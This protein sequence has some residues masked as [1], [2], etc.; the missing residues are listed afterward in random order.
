MQL[1]E[2]PQAGDIIDN[3][4][5]M[6]PSRLQVVEG[7]VDIPDQPNMTF[8]Y[9][10]SGSVKL[11]STKG[12]ADVPE[13]GY[14][15]LAR[16]FRIEVYGQ[17]VL[18]TRYGYIGQYNVG[19]IEQRGRL[20]YIDGCSDTMLYYP[21]RMGDPVFNHLHFPRGIIQSQ[22]THPSVRLG[23]VARGAGHAFGPEVLGES[24]MWFKALTKGCVF[25]LEEQEMHS[26]R[27]DSS[28][29]SMDVIAYH[30][31]SD[32]GPTDQGHPM[33]NRTYIGA[34]VFARGNTSVGDENAPPVPE[35]PEEPEN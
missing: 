11:F 10:L 1:I 15:C 2:T 3:I 31:D 14:F 24:A 30:P 26:F 35:E 16:D 20:S 29:S 13:E 8:C 23:I 21:P 4:N 22:H 7:N 12:N 27:T 17:A 6:Y 33:L 28:Q 25:M 18:I 32:W 34:N 5:G 9:V 19:K